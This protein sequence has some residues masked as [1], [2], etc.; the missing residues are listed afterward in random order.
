MYYDI[1]SVCGKSKVIEVG[2]GELE[3]EIFQSLFIFHTQLQLN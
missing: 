3:E 2:G 1:R